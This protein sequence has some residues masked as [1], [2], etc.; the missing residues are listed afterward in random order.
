MLLPSHLNMKNSKC[1]GLVLGL[2]IVVATS[3]CERDMRIK[4]DGKNPPTFTFSGNGNL[5][6]LLLAD[7]H[8][9]EPP[10]LG[11]PEIWR[12][13]PS[14]DEPKVYQLPSITYGI[15][16]SGFMQVT[17]KGGAPPPLNEG[18]TYEFGGPNS[19]ANGGSIWFTIQHGKSVEVP[20]PGA[21]QF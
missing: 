10:L 6:F 17:P 11:A 5:I 15:V 8:N 2:L 21:N 4:I 14:G 9:N 3:G 20:M 19:N 7:V 13:Q 18:R 16:P 12:I 1:A